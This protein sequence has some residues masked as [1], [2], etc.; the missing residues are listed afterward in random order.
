LLAW[1]FV[2][3]GG[4]RRPL[5]TTQNA[6]VQSLFTASEQFDLIPLKKFL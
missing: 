3:V 6:S 2:V 4:V 1:L 5:S